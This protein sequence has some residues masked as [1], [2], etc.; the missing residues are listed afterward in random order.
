MK[1]LSAIYNLISI[2]I[3]LVV[4]VLTCHEASG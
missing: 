3:V 1:Q 4:G 2:I